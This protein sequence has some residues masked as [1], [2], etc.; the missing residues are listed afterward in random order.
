[1]NPF[2]GRKSHE[3]K[4]PLLA[5][6]PCR[7][8]CLAGTILPYWYFIPWL[9][10]NGLQPALFVRELLANRI[11]A[12]FAMDVIVSACVL[13]AFVRIEKSRLP[14]RWSW[15]PVLAVVTVGV[16]LGLPLFLYLRELE[17][18]RAKSLSAW[19]T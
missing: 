12:F 3:A 4:N 15:L 8:M 10:T 19:S 1:M 16:S 11:S 13:I 5:D 2:W 18:E 7:L 17:L 14:I 9:S 6:V